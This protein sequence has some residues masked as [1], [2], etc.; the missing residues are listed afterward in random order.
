MQTSFVKNKFL[1][2]SYLANFVTKKPYP[3]TAFVLFL[4]T[5]KYDRINCNF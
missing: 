2:K 3:I 1:L 5:E 4:K